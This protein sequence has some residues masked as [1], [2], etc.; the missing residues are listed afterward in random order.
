MKKELIEELL[1]Q[2]ASKP[3]ANGVVNQLK[4]LSQE[5]EMMDY[6]ICISDKMIPAEQVILKANQIAHSDCGLSKEEIKLDKEKQKTLK[7][8]RQ[9]KMNHSTITGVLKLTKN[10]MINDK[11]INY[12]NKYKM[13]MTDH[14]LRQHIAKLLMEE[15]EDK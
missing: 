15:L 10:K 14:Q 7:L 3:V 8:M 1:E 13:M 2:G 9:I 11:V 12:I 4:N 6:L 5:V